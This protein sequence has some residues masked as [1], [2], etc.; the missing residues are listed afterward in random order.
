MF[1]HKYGMKSLLLEASPAEAEDAV[2][3]AIVQHFVGA[4]DLSKGSRAEAGER[5]R[6]ELTGKEI[7]APRL[8]QKMH[9]F[10]DASGDFGY[11]DSMRADNN[12]QAADPG[13]TDRALSKIISR[14]SSPGTASSY[15][16]TGLPPSPQS[17]F[18]VCY[19][20]DGKEI[21]SDWRIEDIWMAASST[22]EVDV[23][24]LWTN[25][26]STSF[27][28]DFDPD[29]NG[30]TG[31]QMKETCL[32]YFHVKKSRSTGGK[33]P[34]L[35]NSTTT[36][37]EI[38]GKSSAGAKNIQA[39]AVSNGVINQALRS[40]TVNRSR[41]PEPGSA[42]WNNQR[43]ANQAI[44]NAVGVIQDYINDRL[45][46]NHWTI[47]IDH[48]LGQGTCTELSETDSVLDV[49]AHGK[50]IRV[51]TFAG[52]SFTLRETQGNLVIKDYES[53]T[54]NTGIEKE[55][56]NPATDVDDH[57]WENEFNG[58]MQMGLKPAQN[59]K[60][61]YLMVNMYTESGEGKLKPGRRGYGTGEMKWDKFSRFDGHPRFTDQ[62]L[63][64]QNFEE[65]LDDIISPRLQ[66]LGKLPTGKTWRDIK[67]A[68]EVWAHII[69]DSNEY[70]MESNEDTLEAKLGY[71]SY[72]EDKAQQKQLAMD[73]A[74][75]KGAMQDVLKGLKANEEKLAALVDRMGVPGKKNES[76]RRRRKYS[77][78]GN[79]FD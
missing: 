33:E 74:E 69:M 45:S 11:Q 65:V 44:Q 54:S 42:A 30:A 78:M 47:Q 64:A 7:L 6:G 15:N 53:G 25:T 3:F 63:K 73:K 66:A 62:Y 32:Y 22:A 8:L 52:G 38:F 71:L 68:P 35:F 1:W 24:V 18:P 75:A 31:N 49:V 37:T 23:N 34:R 76:R 41:W 16:I 46:G 27:L 79:L 13:E 57:Y 9:K 5:K 61:L 21:Q 2:F 39:R 17:L 19:T 26:A 36:A 59:T 55:T 4:R 58:N 12:A 48:N 43:V 72:V 14:P 40:A 77:L 50:Q 56:N 60:F 29:G 28:G 51:T 70:Y 10:M 67:L 20:S